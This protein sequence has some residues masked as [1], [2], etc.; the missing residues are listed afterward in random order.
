M[1]LPEEEGHITYNT[2]IPHLSRG[3]MWCCRRLNAADAPPITTILKGKS[4]IL[5][6]IMSHVFKKSD[7]SSHTLTTENTG[8][9]VV[10]TRNNRFARQVGLI[11]E[12]KTPTLSWDIAHPL[13]A[14][15]V[16]L[17]DLHTEE[18][19]SPPGPK[20]TDSRFG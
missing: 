11:P 6:T 4:F 5:Q 8:T 12:S 13:I 18:M 16:L 2:N 17:F 19:C 9:S 1:F 10:H 3:N 15:A 14:Q 7:V 20:W